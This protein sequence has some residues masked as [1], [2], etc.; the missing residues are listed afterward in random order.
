ML[1][2]RVAAMHCAFKALWLSVQKSCGARLGG[3][4]DAWR[5]RWSGFWSKTSELS[6]WCTSQGNVRGAR[7]DT[8]V[9]RVYRMGGHIIFGQG[10]AGPPR[11]ANFLCGQL[12][13]K[14]FGQVPSPT[15]GKERVAHMAMSRCRGGRTYQSSLSGPV[16][17]RNG[18]HS[19]IKAFGSSMR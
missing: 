7:P 6:A 1:S 5:R 14:K 12:K 18:T 13:G 9:K 17:G 16:S 19:Q 11:L 2:A 4:S 3:V 10:F 15:C 8:G